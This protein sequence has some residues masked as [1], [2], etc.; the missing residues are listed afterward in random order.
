VSEGF[1]YVTGSHRQ[2]LHRGEQTCR[3]DQ[4]LATMEREFVQEKD[5]LYRMPSI[6]GN[7]SSMA[8]RSGE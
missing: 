3:F 8:L 5:A 4:G 7:T 1:L 6:F 2:R